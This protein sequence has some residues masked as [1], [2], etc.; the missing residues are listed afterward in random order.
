MAGITETA[1]FRRTIRLLVPSTLFVLLAILVIVPF[2]TLLYA[3]LITAA[4]F[5]GNDYSWTIRNYLEIWTPELGRAIGN[6]AIVA[7]GGTAIAMAIGC[8]MAWLVAR[9]DIPGKPIVHLAGMMPLFVSLVVASVTWSLLGSGR[10][11]YINIIF[12]AMGLPWRIQLQSLG[13]IIFV[14]GLYYVP[15][16]FLFLYSALTLVHPDLEEAAA[17]HG[18]TLPRILNRITFPLV[19]PALVGSAL[20]LIVLMAEDFPVPQILGGPV[21]IETL[22]IRIY[23]LMT[24]VPASP[25]RASAVAILLTLVVCALVYTQRRILG[26]RD[27]R[28]VTGK[29]IQSRILPLG[30]LRWVAFAFVMLYAFI[31]MGLPMLALLEGALRSNLYIPNVASFFDPAQ[32]SLKHLSQAIMSSSVQLGLKNSLIAGVSTAVFGGIFYFVLVYVVHRTDLPGRRLLE[33]VAMMPLGLPALVMGLG[34]LWTWAAVPLPIYGTMAILVIAFTGRFMPQGYRAISSSITQI[35]DDLENAAMVAGASRARAVRR[36]TLPLM[37][38]GIAA[39]SFLMI[40]LGIRELTASLFLYTTNT[41]VLSIVLFEQY[42]NGIW[43]SVASIS[44]IY[45]ALLV[46]LTLV[47][48][49]WMRAEL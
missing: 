41:R 9:T 5:S 45:T 40:V 7:F 43:S 1:G 32:L 38:G 12:N 2:L 49:R 10:S 13:G 36:I 37:R 27:Y 44:L 39:S 17:I 24:Q 16:P 15:F 25:N 28:T 8:T 48:R 22:S 18:G 34:I 4:P 14:H 31:A 46:A 6:T 20:L 29:G 21:G 33:Y 42:E 35:H 47:G 11:G 23:N 3:S 26:G 30:R 19:K